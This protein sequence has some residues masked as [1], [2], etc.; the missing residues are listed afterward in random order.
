MSLRPEELATL[1]AVV[2]STDPQVTVSHKLRA[3]EM[4]MEGE[5]A[6]G[7][8]GTLALAAWVHELS[9]EEL[10]REVRGHFSPDAHARA[11]AA[12]D[13]RLAELQERE[14]ALAR[15]EEQLAEA[16]R[17]YAKRGRD[18]APERAG[19]E[20]GPTAAEASSEAQEPPRAPLREPPPG[21]ETWAG[22]GGNGGR[23]R[24]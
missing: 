6:H 11:Q 12:L 17:R 2:D 18:R 16:E 3:V 1:Q 5:D 13:R 20:E 15:R 8:D 7:P 14:V 24:R 23:R 9:E 19:A 10:E 21:V 22:F 4:L